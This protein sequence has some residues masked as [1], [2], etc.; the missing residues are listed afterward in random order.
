MS[1]I[2]ELAKEM[3]IK[4]PS[5]A[6]KPI[7][8]MIAKYKKNNKISGDIS[9]RLKKQAIKKHMNRLT[10]KTH[11]E[12]YSTEI[13][14]ALS[15]GKAKKR[16]PL[17]LN[18]SYKKGGSVDKKKK[19][20]SKLH[21]DNLTGIGGGAYGDKG[22]DYSFEADSDKSVTKK[23]NYKT[24]MVTETFKK[25]GKTYTTKYSLDA[26]RRRGEEGEAKL[27]YQTYKSKKKKKTGKKKGGPIKTYAKGGGVRKPKYK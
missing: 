18:V 22:L 4:L 21:M 17:S 13:A 6:V 25:D 15:R 20:K 7:N 14:G 3:D 19:K 26:M 23:V 10:K 16:N 12:E 24:G 8:D 1:S 27:P 9:N 2:K 11:A 5:Y